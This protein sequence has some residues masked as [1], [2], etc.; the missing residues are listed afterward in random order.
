MKKILKIKEKFLYHGACETSSNRSQEIKT[1]KFTAEELEEIEKLPK[2]FDGRKVWG[3]MCPSLNHISDQSGC[4][5]CWAFGTL[6]AMSDR[7]CIKSNGTQQVQLSS[8]HITA[9][10]NRDEGC[11]GGF[12]DRAYDFYENTGV[13]SGGDYN[14]SIGCWP[15]P[16]KPCEHSKYIATTHY[17]LCPPDFYETPKC[18][19]KCQSSYNISFEEDKHFGHAVYTVE[20]DKI[21]LEIF[22]N[23]PVTGSFAL[24][25]DFLSYQGGIYQYVKGALLGGHALKLIGWGVENDKEYWIMSNS[26]NTDWGEKGFVRML[27]YESDIERNI[28]ASL[29]RF[30]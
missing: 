9:C 15:Y 26:W 23:G 7:I 28:Y 24:Y 16:F 19:N 27:Q 20:I 25:E 29:P 11:K 30:K 10:D 2:N 13:V 1:K 17:P 8:V 3:K 5:S 4:G 18:L 6:E 22:K 14:S 12:L 21:K